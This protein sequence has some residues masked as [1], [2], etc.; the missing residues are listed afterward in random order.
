MAAVLLIGL[1]AGAMFGGYLWL[2]E[3]N[4]AAERAAAAQ[5]IGV[6]T[7]GDGVADV[8]YD[9][10]GVVVA[11]PEAVDRDGDGVTDG[12]VDGDGKTVAVVTALDTDGD[13]F[14]DVFVDETG[15]PVANPSAGVDGT[16][17]LD[18][19]ASTATPEDDADSAS[20]ASLPTTTTF[21]GTVSAAGTTDVSDINIVVAPIKLDG[22]AA[23]DANVVAFAGVQASRPG[24]IWSARR[25]SIGNDPGAIRQSEAI[26]PQDLVPGVDGIWRID[27]LPLRQSY[28]LT[29]SKPGFDTQSFVLTPPDSGELVEL[30]V[31]LSAAVGAIRGRIIGPNG[32]LGGADITITDGTLVFETTADTDGD[33]GVFLL[34]RLSTPEVYTLTA[35]LRGY[36]TEVVQVRL[37]AGEQRSD[38]DIRLTRGVGTITG[39]V[40]DEFAR[41]LSGVAISATNGS[42]SRE[43]SSLT[44]GDVGSFSLPQLDIGT[45]YTVNV[46]LDGYSFATR[47]VPVSSSIDGVDFVLVRSTSAISGQVDSSGGGGV[48]AAGVTIASGDLEYRTSTT[49]DPD[50]FFEVDDLPPGNYTVTVA[51]YLHETSTEFLVIVAGQDPSVLEI[52]LTA[53]EELPSVGTGI[54]VVDVVDPDAE[55]VAERPVAAIIQLVLTNSPANNPT[56]IPTSTD[57]APTIRIDSIPPGTYTLTASGVGYADSVP[58]QVSIGLQS[59]RV[60]IELQRKGQA[61]GRMI[62][63]LTGEPVVGLFGLELFLI[64]GNDEIPTNLSITGGPDGLWETASRALQPGDY[65]MRIPEGSAPQGYR[66][67]N[68]QQLDLS[69]SQAMRF[70][71]GGGLQDSNQVLDIEADPFPDISGRVF[72]PRLVGNATQLVPIDVGADPG[73][74]ESLLTAMLTC[75]G[76]PGSVDAT[77]TD[78]FSGGTPAAPL[79]DSFNITKEQIDDAALSGACQVDVSASG[80]VTSTVLLPNL[81]PSNGVA[82]NDRVTNT[83]L[84]SAADTIGGTVF[85]VDDRDGSKVQLDSVDFGT[86]IIV[87]IP[88]NEGPPPPDGPQPIPVR[89]DRTARSDEG[90]WALIGQVFGSATYRIDE[91]GF[92][93]TEFD[94]VIDESRFRVVTVNPGITMSPASPSR[95]PI[96]PGVPYDLELDSPQT[97]AIAGQATIR[98]GTGPAE[99]ADIAIEAFEPLV[100]PTRVPTTLPVNQPAT[101]DGSFTVTQA[102]V[103]TWDVEFTL[104]ANHI[105]YGPT[106]NESFATADPNTR[107]VTERLDPGDPLGIENRFNIEMV[108]LAKINISATNRT[109]GT[110]IITEVRASITPRIVGIGAPQAT[111]DPSVNQPVVPPTSAPFEFTDVVVDVNDPV[112]EAVDYDVSVTLPG[113]DSMSATVR[114]DGVLQPGNLTQLITVPVVAG[115]DTNVVIDIEPY[116]EI[117]AS[118]VGNLDETVAPPT[119]PLNVIRPGETEPGNLAAV[120]VASPVDINGTP[121]LLAPGEAILVE[122]SGVDGQFRVSA[123]EGFYSLAVSHPHFEAPSVIPL[124]NLTYPPNPLVGPPT[125]LPVPGVYEIRNGVT[126]TLT[127]SYQLPIRKAVLR[128]DAVDQ[129]GAPVMPFVY[130]LSS[131]NVT[132]ANGTANGSTVTLTPL[133]PGPYALDIRNG[134]ERFPF[135]S[136]VVIRR[137]E[138]PSRTTI[139][140]APLPAAGATINVSVRAENIHGDLV[141]L[142]ATSV[143]RTYL[144][145]IDGSEADSGDGDVVARPNTGIAEQTLPVDANATGQADF[146][147]TTLVAIGAHTVVADPVDGFTPAGQASVNI[148]DVMNPEAATLSYEALPLDVLITVNAATG[149]SFALGEVSATLTDSSSG[150]V[151]SGVPSGPLTAPVFTFPGQHPTGIG[152]THTL[153]VTDPLYGG[154]TAPFTEPIFIP[155]DLDL[156]GFEVLGPVTATAVQGRLVGELTQDNNP[157]SDLLISEATVTMTPTG[158]GPAID[159][160]IESDGRYRRLFDAGAYLLTVEAGVGYTTDSQLVTITNGTETI[161]NLDV[162]ALAAVIVNTQPTTLPTGTIITLREVGTTSDEILVSSGSTPLTSPFEFRVEPN[163]K[164]QVFVRGAYPDTYFPPNG[165]NINANGA[166]ITIDLDQIVTVNVTNAPP[167]LIVEVDGETD[168]DA[169]AP[170]VV[171]FPDISTRSLTL[172]VPDGGGATTT[173]GTTQLTDDLL[174]STTIDFATLSGS[175]TISDSA[176]IPAGTTITLASSST[177]ITGPVTENSYSFAGLIGDLS[178]GGRTWT[179]TLNQPGLGEILNGNTISVDGSMSEVTLPLIVTPDEYVVTFDVK[180]QDVSGDLAVVAGATVTMTGAT[181]VP[182]DPLRFTV[183][184]TQGPLSWTASG[185]GASLEVDTGSFDPRAQTTNVTVNARLAQR[186]LA[187]TI[188]GAPTG[189]TFRICR[190]QIGATCEGTDDDAP[191]VGVTSVGTS[192]FSTALSPLPP[193]FGPLAPQSYFVELVQPIP[194]ATDPPATD[195]APAPAPIMLAFTVNADGSVAPTTVTVDNVTVAIFA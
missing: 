143:T 193:T 66:V 47:S 22:L 36:G 59:E 43:T 51:H 173:L 10:N 44:D 147:M 103:G 84:Y 170:Y 90:A 57:P 77:M 7:D 67:E 177:T 163:L 81:L 13:G 120:V 46:Q 2:Q 23:P 63:S 111:P 146:A 182:G 185:G 75:A 69:S 91:Q 94:V 142:P 133:L 68:D 117:L 122:P 31:E 49:N 101:A 65:R 64:I 145:L 48:V 118:I 104:P 135:I 115:R 126:N 14:A 41:P 125:P 32:P 74:G 191:V 139:V 6:D 9:E 18:Q 176:P 21:A 35:R 5:I 86:N 33:V 112:G 83:A 53:L 137:T 195:P 97:Q 132:V 95:E 181:A 4:E 114:V 155:V 40:L 15:A 186:P 110:P 157:A 39:R 60:E 29:F 99:Y 73:T 82:D 127:N 136:D 128:I 162:E 188:T 123:P 26:D 172:K 129:N 171:T 108:D 144:N 72:S 79:F 19:I 25:A 89:E 149:G 165:R 28:K 109:A 106:L 124:N 70:T 184:E 54:L 168:P 166:T 1:W 134:N 98:T 175:L 34:E 52:T 160:T 85:W 141:A 88:P 194:P 154:S 37:D 183:R 159:V 45:T 190:G 178:G 107:R 11:A 100:L 92:D 148:T 93:P 156:D 96:S 152:L 192:P 78:R 16:G 61:G 80:F 167:G 113:F 102:P 121:V 17:E 38:I 158:G 24:K 116:G 12:H 161:S 87:S 151:I 27:G 179:V 3:R 130:T 140:T 174:I 164:Y 187:L 180:G 62:D 58:R 8:F 169:T 55:D 150:D 30:D 42:N 105:F 50:G 76:Q 119:E 153:T 189:S 20:A 138:V 131:N 56:V 71:V